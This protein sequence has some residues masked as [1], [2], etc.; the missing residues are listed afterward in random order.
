VPALDISHD[1]AGLMKLEQHIGLLLKEG[2][3]I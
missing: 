3:S 2:F 1:E